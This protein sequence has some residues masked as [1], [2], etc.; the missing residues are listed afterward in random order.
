MIKYNFESEKINNIKL[1]FQKIISYKAEIKNTFELLDIKINKLKEFYNN[2]IK[3]TDKTLFIFGLDSFYFQSKLIDIELDHMKSLYGLINNKLYSSYYKLFKIIKDY[4]TKSFKETRMKDIVILDIIYP[5]YKDLEPFKDYDFDFT[6]KLHEKIVEIII[7]FDDFLTN[8][9]IEL[10]AYNEKLS[11][12]LNINN[13]ITT[14]NHENMIIKNEIELYI[15][16]IEFIDITYGNYYKKL[17]T[18][19]RIL[20]SQIEN[21]INFDNNKTSD[22]D[23][24]KSLISENSDEL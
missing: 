1:N 20:L 13:F 11:I 15:N 7:F 14:F 4:V 3:T 9:G 10:S 6:V 24:I 18:K 17:I 19:I 2:F 5:I 21:D 22:K 23:M 16:Y 12:G 8:K